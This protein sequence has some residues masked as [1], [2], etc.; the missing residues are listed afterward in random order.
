M[1]HV[2]YGLQPRIGRRAAGQLNAQGP[3]LASRRGKVAKCTD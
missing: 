3:E 1:G 2:A